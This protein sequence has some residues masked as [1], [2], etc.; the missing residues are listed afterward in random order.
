[1]NVTALLVTII[2]CQTGPTINE[3]C[4]DGSEAIS[5]EMAILQHSPEGEVLIRM[6]K[7]NQN[8]FTVW[9]D[10]KVSSLIPPN[11]AALR[12]W[13]AVASAYRDTCPAIGDVLLPMKPK[14]NTE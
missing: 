9:P 2:F 4:E 3:K 8:I 11:E 14:I 10:G 5:Y 13:Q 6:K 1:M 12:F 7:N